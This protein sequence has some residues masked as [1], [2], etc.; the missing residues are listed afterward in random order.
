M[1]MQVVMVM[2][3]MV[4]QVSMLMFMVQSML[5]VMVMG[6]CALRMAV[7]MVLIGKATS[8]V[9]CLAMIGMNVIMIAV[10]SMVM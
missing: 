5:M 4:M 8:V 6:V 2:M 7:V 3:F 9:S 1:V 10:K